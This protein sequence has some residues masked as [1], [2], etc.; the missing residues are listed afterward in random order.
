MNN[1]QE[2][3]S[4]KDYPAAPV[5]LLKS[6]MGKVAAA[7]LAQEGK[8][9]LCVTLF[10]SFLSLFA[11]I[12]SLYRMQISVSENGLWSIFSLLF[13]D[14]EVV[15]AYWKSFIFSLVERLPLL[16]L[17]A[18]SGSLLVFVVT[19]K[20]INTDIKKYFLSRRVLRSIN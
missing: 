3:F 12:L 7:S 5:G 9:H 2:A 6:V 16:S 18:S 10:F 14:F 19:L 11:A 4:K 13:S 15:A 20:A 8:K 1:I 17:I